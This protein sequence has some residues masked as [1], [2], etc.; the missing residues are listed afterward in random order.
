M[1][2]LKKNKKQQWHHLATALP[3]NDT[4]MVASFDVI[5]DCTG[6]MEHQPEVH[7]LKPWSGGRYVTLT[8]PMLSNAD[9]LGA[10]AGAVRTGLDL[11]AANGPALFTA[12]GS[13]RWAFF[14]PNAGALR[15]VAAHLDAGRL[16]PVVDAVYDFERLADAYVR[17]ERGHVRGKIVVAVS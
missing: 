12:G 8:P 10:A 14:A 2:S 15:A 4:L 11:L 5:L 3:T 1:L 16:R 13:V 17:L 7:L 9:R 6:R